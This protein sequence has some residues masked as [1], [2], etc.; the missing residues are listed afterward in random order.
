M[1][2]RQLI[3]RIFEAEEAAVTAPKGGD[4][5]T[6]KIEISGSPKLVQKAIKQLAK[7][8]PAGVKVKAGGETVTADSDDVKVDK[9]PSKDKGP[10]K[11]D[12]KDRPEPKKDAKPGGDDKPK[13]DDKLGDGD[14][15]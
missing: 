3:D 12:A 15:E 11:P 4:Q 8:K 7:E 2:S 10:K 6:V 5:A 13:K 14:D 9:G 1:K